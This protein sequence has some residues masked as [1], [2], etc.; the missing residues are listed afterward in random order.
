MPAGCSLATLTTGGNDAST[1]FS[2]PMSGSGSLAKTGAGTFT[3]TGMST[4]GG[5]LSVGGTN[6]GAVNVGGGSFTANFAAVGN[7]A[8]QVSGG[9]VLNSGGG[10]ID[11]ATATPNALVTGAGSTWNV[12]GNTGFPFNILLIGRTVNF[13]PLGF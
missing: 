8:L 7:G 2:G 3:L 9:G 6:T 1:L 13:S 11:S 4:I 12:T 10:I 5:S